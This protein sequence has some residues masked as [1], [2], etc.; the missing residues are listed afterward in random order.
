MPAGSPS[1]EDAALAASR[2]RHDLGKAVRFSA[3]EAI[4]KDTDALRARLARDVG[5]AREG[6]DAPRSA[7][8]IFD[9]WSAASAG[10]FRAGPGAEALRR[11]GRAIEEMRPLAARVLELP[12][13]DLERLDALTREIAR[14]CRELTAAFRAPEGR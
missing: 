13:P 9:A 12:R 1:N 11:L 4:E 8:A 10:L 14:E 3:P 5:A 6:P 7:A 2:L